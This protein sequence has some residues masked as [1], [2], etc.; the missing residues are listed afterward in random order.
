MAALFGSEPVG[1]E[2]R[3]STLASSR[4][5]SIRACSHAARTRGA[6]RR[7]RLRRRGRFLDRWLG[8][9]PW[10]PPTTVAKGE[11][12]REPTPRLL[13]ESGGVG[14]PS[15]HRGRGRGPRARE[16][17]RPVP[18][19]RSRWCRSFVT[20]GAE[21]P[22]RGRA[23]PRGNATHFPAP[24]SS[25]PG[26]PR[27][28]VGQRAAGSLP[29]SGHGDG[30]N[31]RQMTGQRAEASGCG[32]VR[33]AELRQRGVGAASVSISVSAA[34]DYASIHRAMGGIASVATTPVAW[35][36]AS[37]NKSY[38]PGSLRPLR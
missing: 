28:G 20:E 10:W 3:A 26:L 12:S 17:S 22:S 8:R 31:V 13:Q 27:T 34:G 36:R 18:A 5:S 19:S 32:G 25:S 6:L 11:A 7:C 30:G 29:H 1:A 33:L 21:T 4:T 35:G 16:T 37:R 15:R 38:R 9:F 23:G 2:P 24:P 14:P